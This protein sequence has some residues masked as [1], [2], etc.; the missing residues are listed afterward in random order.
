MQMRI[1][2]I[3]IDMMVAVVA[4]AQKRTIELAA[5][6]LGLT[7][8]AVHKRIQAVSGPIGK[9]LF[10]K[11]EQI[12]GVQRR[13]QGLP[14]YRP[15]LRTTRCRQDALSSTLQS[16]GLLGWLRLM[17]RRNDAFHHARYCHVHR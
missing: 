1:R 4:L 6:E 12:C 15:V 8:S 9:P 16:C 10:S 11:P 13:L 3:T 2:R 17:E 5:K 14:V 7:S